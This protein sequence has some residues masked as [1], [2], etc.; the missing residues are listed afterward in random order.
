MQAAE[1][2]RIVGQA[3]GHLEPDGDGLVVE[4][5]ERLPEPI[6]A[7]QGRLGTKDETRGRN[8][9]RRTI[10]GRRRNVIHIFSDG[11]LSPRT[12][13]NGPIGPDPSVSAASGAENMGR[14]FEDEEKPAHETG[15]KPQ[16][17]R[18]PGSIGPIGPQ[19]EH[20]PRPSDESFTDGASPGDEP[21]T[22][23]PTTGKWQERI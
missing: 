5:P 22:P 12:G 13:P 3:G 8:M 18:D 6:M 15:P 1:L 14:L 21:E 4:A 7:E 19:M 11:P 9:A 2:I 10:C 17:N 20:K 16:E 23:A